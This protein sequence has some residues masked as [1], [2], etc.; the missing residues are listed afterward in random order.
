MFFLISYIYFASPDIRLV[1]LT[2][3]YILVVVKSIKEIFSKYLEILKTSVFALKI[4]SHHNI[5]C[6]LSNELLVRIV[7]TNFRKRIL[8]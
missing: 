2:L 8:M 3:D 7:D 4:N 1:C 5:L 6:K